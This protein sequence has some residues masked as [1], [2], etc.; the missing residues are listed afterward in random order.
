MIDGSKELAQD[1]IPS[2]GSPCTDKD[3]DREAVSPSKDTL[4]D[5]ENT[6]VERDVVQSPSLP[7]DRDISVIAQAAEE[8]D[9]AEPDSLSFQDPAPIIHST[10]PHL[11]FSFPAITLYTSESPDKPGSFLMDGLYPPLE[12]SVLER[13]ASENEE[14]LSSASDSLK[15]GEQGGMQDI[16]VD[17]L[18]QNDVSMQD[19]TSEYQPLP[20]P[21]VE[22]PDNAKFS[23]IQD[24][25]VELPDLEVTGTQPY[26]V[27]SVNSEIV[28]DIV[29]VDSVIEV[30]GQSGERLEGEVHEVGT[31]VSNS[32]D[33]EQKSVF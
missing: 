8:E 24:D 20:S 27:E 11:A 4:Q 1:D 29:D 18:N 33:T 22:Q 7:Q 12:S 23:G 17:G 13:T 16:T 5:I 25:V 9:H 6:N 31:E 3:G 26:D 30:D 10:P 28:D 14:G 32:N 2:A 15:V 21:G 19:L